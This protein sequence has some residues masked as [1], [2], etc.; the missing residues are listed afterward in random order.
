MGLDG[1]TVGTDAVSMGT[2]KRAR[3]EDRW[4]LGTSAFQLGTSATLTPFTPSDKVIPNVIAG[5]LTTFVR[6]DF[7][8][9][10]TA[11]TWFSAVVR[12]GGEK[13]LLSQIPFFIIWYTNS[14]ATGHFSR[15]AH[16]FQ[17]RT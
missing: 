6:K 3:G 1:W 13:Y 14:A 5:K 9:D 7:P 12:Y 16:F 17:G 11:L 15:V 4:T 2:G 8:N 10:G